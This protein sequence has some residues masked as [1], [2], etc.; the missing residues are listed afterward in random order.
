MVA[1]FDNATFVEVGTWKGRSASYMAVE[2]ANSNKNIKFYCVDPWTGEAKIGAK[3][4]IC[5]E[6]T[7][8][9]LYEC[10]LKNIEPVKD[11]I[12]PL[13]MLSAEGSTQFE[14]GSLYF[15]FL[16]ASNDYESV[17]EDISLWWPKIKIGGVLAGHDYKFPGV[18]KAVH[19]FIDA[20]GLL[21]DDIGQ[22]SWSLFAKTHS[23][24][25]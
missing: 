10:F 8:K 1:K 2:I 17:K 24:E 7:S 12:S 9:T 14:D 18:N 20:H 3:S 22:G 23:A 16:D 19:E 11:Y 15:V 5:E 21:L 4:F 6:V 25:N 13:R